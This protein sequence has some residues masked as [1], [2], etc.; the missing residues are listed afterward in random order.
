MLDLRRWSYGKIGDC[1]QF[2]EQF[3]RTD[4]QGTS[5]FEALLSSSWNENVARKPGLLHKLQTVLYCFFL[6][7]KKYRVSNKC[8]KRLFYECVILGNRWSSCI[9]I[10]IIVWLESLGKIIFRL[11]T[12]LK[13]KITTFDTWLI[14]YKKGGG[15]GSCSLVTCGSFRLQRGTR[16]PCRLKGNFHKTEVRDR[17]MPAALY[18]YSIHELSFYVLCRNRGQVFSVC[19]KWKGFCH[20]QKNLNK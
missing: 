11:N 9:T 6:P 14:S 10:T 2:D 5:K 1:E 17:L 12:A 16:N 20:G 3:G 4:W 18:L 15:G 19:D 13:L 7:L 8:R